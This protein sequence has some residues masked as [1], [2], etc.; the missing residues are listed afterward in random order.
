MKPW[1]DILS[2]MALAT[3]HCFSSLTRARE[4][5]PHE[6]LAYRPLV[7]QSVNEPQTLTGG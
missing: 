4:A 5:W 1:P 3:G 6:N 7:K 2:G